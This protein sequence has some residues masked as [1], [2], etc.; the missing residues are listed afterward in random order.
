M[1]YSSIK[2]WSIKSWSTS[3][4][5]AAAALGVAASCTSTS[6]GYTSNTSSHSDAGSSGGAHNTGGAAGNG[7]AAGAHGVTL[8]GNIALADL[9]DPY[10]QAVCTSLQNCLGDLLNTF[11]A[12]EDCSKRFSATIG[13]QLPRIQAA[14]DAGKAEYHSDKIAACLN[15]LS[16]RS[17]DTLLQRDPASCL[18][19]VDGTVAIGDNCQSNVECA[20]RAY[21]DFT[22]T[23][24][25][26]CKALE[27][28]GGAC[29]ND[30]QCAPGLNCNTTTKHCT[31]PAAQNED[32]GAGGADCATGLLCV[33]AM[34]N[35]PGKCQPYAGL[36]AAQAGESC[37]LQGQQLCDLSL[38]C[39]VDSVAADGGAQES[40][41]E[42]VAAGAMC[43][44]SG[45]D[46]CPSDE[47][48]KIAVPGSLTG[49]CTSKPTAGEAC[50]R[51]PFEPT[52]TTCA[53]YNRCQAGICRKIA[54][55]GE[56]CTTDNGCYSGRCVMQACIPADSCQ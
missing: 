11:L 3:V 54:Q 6:G 25:G 16:A 47:Y 19:A 27:L 43:R 26:K 32:C 17:C 37:D 13:E 14:I 41:A 56:Q 29:V 52:P 39:R 49:R 22:Q 35:T 36:F 44:A 40:C 21:C 55:L 45:P 2:N 34:T 4:M 7:G 46:I 12:G 53:L 18:A 9:A 5:A 48:C 51:G 33:G 31:Q 38:V 50:G 20:G 15:D 1:R 24:P 8:S 30:D 28:A 23:C 42:H 10:S